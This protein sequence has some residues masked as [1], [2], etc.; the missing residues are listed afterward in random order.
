MTNYARVRGMRRVVDRCATQRTTVLTA[1]GL[2]VVVAQG[3]FSPQ[4]CPGSVALAAM[5]LGFVSPDTQVLEMGSG[6]GLASVAAAIR[7][8]SVVAVDLNQAAARNTRINTLLHNVDQSVEVYEGDL[9]EPL[10]PGR[11]FDVVYWNV[12][13]GNV[14]EGDV[15]S[16]IDSAVFDPGYRSLARFLAG[17]SRFLAHGASV[18]IGFSPTFGDSTAITQLACAHGFTSRL[19]DEVTALDLGFD[20]SDEPLWT[21]YQLHVLRRHEVA[22]Q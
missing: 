16:V 11:R 18:L 10:P 6:I 2:D 3:V 7:G 20:G 19:H 13:W 15:C 9:F 12:P 8:A 1:L 14:A 17:V 21:T 4:F 5:F 22:G